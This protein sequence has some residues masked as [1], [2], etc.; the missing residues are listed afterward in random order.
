[1]RDATDCCH[2]RPGRN[3]DCQDAGRPRDFQNDP[4]IN[5]QTI[6]APGSSNPKTC[7]PRRS[8]PFLPSSQQSASGFTNQHKHQ[9][10][11]QSR[12][13]AQATHRH[14]RHTNQ[15]ERA[16]AVGLEA[17]ATRAPSRTSALP[18]NDHSRRQPI[19]SSCE[20]FRG[21]APVAKHSSRRA[22]ARRALL[23]LCRSR[24]TQVGKQRDDFWERLGGVDLMRASFAK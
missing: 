8:D 12:G 1:M 21:N 22:A 16:C 10:F 5:A 11:W 23:D 13:I 9:G 2:W 17:L 19:V 15:P 24:P 14:Q 20:R 3:S 18:R 6:E 7:W 4:A